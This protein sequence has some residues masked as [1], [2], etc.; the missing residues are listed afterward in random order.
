M[1]VCTGAHAIRLGNTMFGFAFLC[2]TE[3]ELS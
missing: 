2:G 1:L 3:V